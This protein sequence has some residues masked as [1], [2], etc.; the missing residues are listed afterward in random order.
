MAA[1]DTAIYHGLIWTDGNGNLLAYDATIDPTTGE[2]IPGPNHGRSIA[3]H[4]GSYVFLNPGDPSHNDRHGTNVLEVTGTVDSSMT[5]DETLVNADETQN[6][7]HFGVQE[8]DPHYD[9]DAPNGVR[10]TSL[11]PRDAEMLTGHTDA[12]ANTGGGES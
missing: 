7:H 5:D 10:L 3:F 9:A 1:E 12:P 6:Q 8:D 11:S 2:E 4:E